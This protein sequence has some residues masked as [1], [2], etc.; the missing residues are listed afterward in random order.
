M[1]RRQ[2][3]QPTRLHL[4][5][6]RRTANALGVTIPPILYMFADE[7]IEWQRPRWSRQKVAPRP[8]KS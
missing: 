4:V 8:A 2:F 3:E 7:I 1:R 6:N 5:I